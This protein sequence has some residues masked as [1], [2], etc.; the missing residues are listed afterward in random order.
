MIRGS[1][2]YYNELFFRG[3][4][5]QLPEGILVILAE[6]GSTPVAAAVFF[7]SDTHLY[8]RYWGSDGH[9][10][11]LHFETCYY[12]SIEYCITIRWVR[13]YWRSGRIKLM[14]FLF[15]FFQKMLTVWIILNFVHFD[16]I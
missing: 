15:R 5:E 8:G 10:D 13:F 1:M 2:P 7:E 3:L 4:S 14:S 9:Y 16:I 12:Q 6:I 11:S